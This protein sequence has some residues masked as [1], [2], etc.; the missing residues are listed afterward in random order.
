M[1]IRSQEYWRKRFEAITIRNGNNGDAN[2]KAIN[3]LY[4]IANKDI[5]KEINAFYGKYGKIEESPVFTTL[6]NGTKVISGTSSKLIVPAAVAYFSLKKGTRLSK[7]QSQLYDILKDL[8]KENNQVFKAGLGTTAKDMYYDSLYE[9]YRGVGIGT[10]FNLLTEPQVLSLIRNEVNGQNFSTRI[11]NNRDKLANVV[12]QTLKTGITQ[13]LSNG[14]MTKRISENMKSGQKVTARLLRTEVTNSMAQAAKISYERSGIVK[15]Y[16]YIATLDNLTSSICTAL[17]GEVFKVSEAV[18]GL[19]YPPMH[20]NCRSTT[21]AYF[22][23]PDTTRVAR[24]LKGDVYT[25]PANM[26]AKDWRAV[27]LDKTMT[28]EQW[29]RRK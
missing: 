26:T 7:L 5:S 24:D 17:D 20:P 16:I 13:G 29:E 21:S 18:A 4:K 3:N 25:V 22:D 15:E 27:Y 6:E 9:I 11:W 19:N 8:A 23:E 28:R 2:I 1:P 10:S 14:E 12:N